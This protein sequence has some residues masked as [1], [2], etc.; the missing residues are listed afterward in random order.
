MQF[1]LKDRLITAIGLFIITVSLTIGFAWLPSIAPAFSNPPQS[2]TDSSFEQG[3]QRYSKGQYFAATEAFRQAEQFYKTQNLPL[4]RSAALSNLS[5][6]YQQLESWTEAQ[7]AIDES[8]ALLEN[9]K[10]EKGTVLA[11]ALEIQG[12]LQLSMGQSDRALDTWQQAEKNYVKN[13]DR[14]G[15]LRTQLNQAKALQVKGFYRRALNL[16]ETVEAQLKTDPD[17]VT[18]A[19]ALRSL[20]DTLQ[21]TGDLTQARQALQSSLEIA[22]RLKRPE[23]ISAALFSLG[24]TARSQQDIQGAIAFYTQ[25][26]A[27]A[28]TPL[29][30]LQPKINHFSLLKDP[31][32]QSTA[33]DLLRD[34]ES[35]L[36]QLS[37]SHASAY[38]HINVAQAT[39][40][41]LRDW[42]SAQ[43]D[44]LL[45]R[46]LTQSMTQLLTT[47]TEQSKILKDEYTHA[48]A[49]GT[50][51]ALQEQRGELE[52]A[53]QSTE[54]ALFIAQSLKASESIYRWQW[55]LGRILNAQGQ[56]QTSK[57]AYQSAIETLRSLRSNLAAINR[58]VQFDFRDSVE[59]VYRETVAV[60]FEIQKTQPNEQNLEQA[61]T[62]MDQ[63]QLAELD[64]FF[65]E[66]CLNGTQVVLDQLVDQQNPTT[67]ILYPIILDRQ[68]QVIVKIP[69]Q[70]LRNYAIN[71]SHTTTETLLKKLRSQLVQSSGEK[72]TQRLSQ[73]V[74]KWLIEP[75]ESSLANAG[76]NTLVFVLD[77]EFRNLPMAALYDGKQYLIEKYAVAISGG[78][79][80]LQPQ[81]INP[82]QTLTAIAAGLTTPP[83]AFQA[84][85]YATLPEI[86]TELSLI[87]Q[88]G[89][90]TKILLDQ[91][92]DR[93]TLAE[94]VK[95]KPLNIVHLAT[96]GNFSSNAN[97]TY[98]LASDG[99]IFVSEFDSLLRDRGQS[100]AEAIE[101]LV[102][103]ACQTAAGDDRATL[104]LAGVAIRAG[105]RSTL[106][107]L[108]Q[109]DD[110]ATALLMG[111]FY[112]ELATAKV[113]KAEALR[114]AQVS[115]IRNDRLKNNSLNESSGYA[116]PRYWA[117]YVLVGNWL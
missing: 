30:R 58:D 24:N 23:V 116:R 1:K 104:G 114:R 40:T 59:P 95:S 75:I 3:T 18:K 86:K 98:I 17:S 52:K 9:I 74:Y 94:A 10:S 97:E 28:T 48:Y 88:S 117:A 66:A 85:G 56:L 73:Q 34:I 99:A 42:N 71:Q 31:S 102:L 32:Q 19:T 101:L 5:L 4:R 76:V 113:S 105:A 84:Q 81:A 57:D 12:G 77:G 43:N 53:Q 63:L 70:P 41:R 68:L 110:R 87:Q 26:S 8:L 33:L 103:S 14:S 72:A 36:P 37:V 60:L 107:S 13:Q 29:A 109:V 50:L 16:L 82:D 112:R 93:N 27:T 100:Q 106:A 2:V 65:R 6:A 115:L 61:R 55:Q 69:K 35:Q 90:K 47:A 44:R 64:D 7:T 89:I 22:Q 54:Q 11:Q 38:A 21:L 62:L 20:G 15:L 79:Q 83:P 78:L 39:L 46:L 67:A 96:H 45:S 49:I 92:F 111:E 25:A 108:W 51:G 91:A 80:L